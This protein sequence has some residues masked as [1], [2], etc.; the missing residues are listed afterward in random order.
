[1]SESDNFREILSS[2]DCFAK[3]L[4]NAN[5]SRSFNSSF[6]FAFF[7]LKAPIEFH[8]R[9]EHVS[10][11]FGSLCLRHVNHM[12]DECKRK[13]NTNFQ[14]KLSSSSPT[15]CL[16][17]EQHEH[18]KP[19]VLCNTHFSTYFVWE[20]VLTHEQFQFTGQTH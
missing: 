9:R 16:R 2:L 5:S 19:G 7:W 17:A 8:N 12:I 1:M 11:R 13:T 14:W 20:N 6:L 3:N 4:S 15:L 18:Q 10:T